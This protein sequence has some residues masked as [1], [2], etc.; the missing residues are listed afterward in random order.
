MRRQAEIESEFILR[1]RVRVLPPRPRLRA[2]QQRK[3]RQLPLRHCRP[4][5]L[6]APVPPPAGSVLLRRDGKLRIF[7][8]LVTLTASSQMGTSSSSV[9]ISRA[10]QRFEDPNTEKL[11]LAI[12]NTILVL[13]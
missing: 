1:D 11:E 7:G 3:L 12:T 4:A 2:D 10:A 6:A 8:S 9:M 13:P 5:G